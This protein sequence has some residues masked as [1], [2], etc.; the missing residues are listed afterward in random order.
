MCYEK[1]LGVTGVRAQTLF[2]NLSTGNVLNRKAGLRV[3][4]FVILHTY[5]DSPKFISVW[6][7]DLE[8]IEKI[9]LGKLFY[10][11]L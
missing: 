3:D 1:K 6:K 8:V 4:L 10:K 11:I 5:W 9:N 7:K 2:M